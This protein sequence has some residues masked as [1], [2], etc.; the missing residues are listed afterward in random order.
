[1]AR[2]LRELRAP[3]DEFYVYI[4]IEQC[5]NVCQ[6][7]SYHWVRQSVSKHRARLVMVDI[8]LVPEQPSFGLAG[9]PFVSRHLTR[10]EL[11]YV[12]LMDR[13]LDFSRCQA[14]EDL[15]MFTCDIGTKRILSPSLKRLRIDYCDFCKKGSR[16]RISAPNLIWLKLEH[17]MGTSPA[18]ESMPLLESAIVR[19]DCNHHYYNDDY[20]CANGGSG[21]CCGLCEG[22]VGNDEHS[23]GC[24][25]LQGLSSATHLE[26]TVPFAKFADTISYP[27]FT[28]LKT[29]LLDEWSVAADFRAL[30]CIL[31]YSP[32]L[33]KFTINLNKALKS[34]TELEGNNHPSV[35]LASVSENL[36]IVKVKC[37]GVDER[38]SKISKLFSAFDIQVS[39]E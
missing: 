27:A 10:L 33:E 8:E 22:C 38:V 16:T 23:G 21:E 15:V 2:L 19:L 37:F 28:K 39:V 9:K 11:C 20:P 24:L 34:T 1:M 25:L 35:Q 18:L 26:L 29:L 7:E 31:Q 4:E 12:I 36:K 17:L 30:I 32:N 13:I 14:L 6:L 5:D 3:L